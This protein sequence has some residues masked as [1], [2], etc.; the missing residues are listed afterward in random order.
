MLAGTTESGVALS[1]QRER[2]RKMSSQSNFLRLLGQKVC[3]LGG[4][5]H[6]RV[7]AFF[8]YV[9]ELSLLSSTSF[10]CLYRHL[11]FFRFCRE[12]QAVRPGVCVGPTA[13]P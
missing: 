11:C 8:Q 4:T 2:E 12:G 9:S 7:E 13:S 6:A 3:L 10:S 5:L 1:V